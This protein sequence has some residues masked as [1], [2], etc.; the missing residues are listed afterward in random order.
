[1]KENP[2]NYGPITLLPALSKILE[3]VIENQLISLLDKH[4]IFNKSQFGFGKNK[5]TKDATA[6]IIKNIIENLNNKIKRNCVLS[7]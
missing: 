5:S 6:T 2:N 4:N 1:M 3:K 7:D